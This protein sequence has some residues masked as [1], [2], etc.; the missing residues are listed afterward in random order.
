MSAIDKK[1]AELGIT[2]PNPPA[3]IAAYVP[4]VVTDRLVFVAGQ[5]PSENGQVKYTGT[6]GADVDIAT[7]QKAARLCALNVIA[8]VRSACGG[9]LD[10]VERCVKLG[11]FV[12]STPSFT[13][14]AQIINGASELMQE[15]FGEAGKHARFAVGANVL[16]RNACVEVD[17]IFALRG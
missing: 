6:V 1:L 9:D 11:G 15:V 5:V 8:Q 4:Y 17:A 14:Q 16:P 2:L 13:D 3:P 7:G 12:A 10:R